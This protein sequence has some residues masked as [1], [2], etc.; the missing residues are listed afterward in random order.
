M[1]VSFN[2]EN[3]RV[4]EKTN[5]NRVILTIETDGTISAQDAYE[6]SSQVLIDQFQAVSQLERKPKVTKKESA[7]SPK[8]EA[9]EETKVAKT[10]Q[11]DQSLSGRFFITNLKLSSRIEKILKR[12][13]VKTIAQLMQKSEA[14]LLKIDG[15]GDSAVKEIR[16]KLGKAGF[17]LGNK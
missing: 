10:T 12:H 5:Y 11:T 14:N 2:V 3:M 6:H 16:R 8:K 9:K 17:I 4:G 7:K 13:R 1:S 15:I